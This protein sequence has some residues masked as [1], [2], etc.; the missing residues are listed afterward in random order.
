[1]EIQVVLYKAGMN[2]SG[3]ISKD[4]VDIIVQKLSNSFF[5]FCVHFHTHILIYYN[6]YVCNCN[7]LKA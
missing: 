5:A 4:N 2:K 6:V 7:I 1:M 3:H